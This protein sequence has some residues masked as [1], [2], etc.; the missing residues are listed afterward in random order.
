MPCRGS[1]QNPDFEK[2][3]RSNNVISS[4]N[5][6]CMKEKK[7][8][9]GYLWIIRNQETYQSIIMYAPC[10]GIDS[11]RQIVMLKRLFIGQLNV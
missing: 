3:Y 10:L 1:R 4:T 6:S 9:K 2:L 8:Q 11:N 5:L 7:R